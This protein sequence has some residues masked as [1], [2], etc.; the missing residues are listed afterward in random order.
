MKHR[1]LTIALV[2]SLLIG[3]LGATSMYGASAEAT[4]NE[5]GYPIFSEPVNMTMMLSLNTTRGVEP[6]KNSVFQYLEELTNIDWTYNT[7]DS[8]SWS[9]RVNL[10][11][12]SENM[13]DIIWN[14]AGGPDAIMKYLRIGKIMDIAPYVEQYAPNFKAIID[15]NPAVRMAVTTP[16][17]Q[18]G[19]F[20]FGNMDTEEGK[21]Q[22]PPEFLLVNQEWLGKFGLDNPS[23]PDEVYHVLKTFMDNDANGN[24]QADE[25]GLAFISWS[26]SGLRILF[27]WFGIMAGT[28]N[29]FLDGD[30][31]K[32]APFTPEYKEAVSYL[33]KLY[34]E[35][36]IDKDIFTITGAEVTAKGSGEVPVYGGL[37]CSAAFLIVSEKYADMYDITPLIQAPNGNDMWYTRSYP[38]G[39]GTGVITTSCKYPEAAVRFC[40]L[41]YDAAYE[42]L[43]WMGLEGVAYIVN[44]DGSWDWNYE[45]TEEKTA[46]AVRAQHTLQPGSNGPGICPP[47]WFKLADKA[48]APV[49]AQRSRFGLENSGKLRIALPLM[50]YEEADAREIATIASDANAYENEMFAKF[51]TGEA[52]I[53]KDYDA[54]VAQ[55]KAMGVEEAVAIMQRTYDN[56]K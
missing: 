31:V 34:A 19:T 20:F 38:A 45:S 22:C 46:T 6:E 53:E 2:V 44:E 30:T 39:I 11:W 24:G 10:M 37:M 29:S 16:E 3:M 40:D 52:S 8:A 13:P 50:Y 17:G 5:T 32:Y 12:A 4:F 56:N 27:P 15:S 41:F 47:E 35:G 7:V 55:L 43:P 14:G 26:A 51:V 42:K 23:T 18:I 49:N 21:G 9:E 25:M 54:F 1:F 33:N 28:N 48:E 36:L